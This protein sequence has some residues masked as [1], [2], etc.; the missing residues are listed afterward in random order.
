MAYKTNGYQ[1]K[2]DKFGRII[3]SGGTLRL[4]QGIRNP[5]AQL[6]A[7][8]VDRLI[9]DHG[10]HLIG[11]R[12][13]GSGNLDNL[14]AGDSNLNLSAY[15]KLENILAQAL[16]DGK[17][18]TVNIQPKYEGTSLRPSKLDIKYSIDNEKFSDVLLNKSGSK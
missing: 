18:V 1:Y 12:F 6:S 5:N 7:G 4:E 8:G 9:T 15:K 10:S 3:E 14:V 2:S 11:T 17:S 16:K 13:G